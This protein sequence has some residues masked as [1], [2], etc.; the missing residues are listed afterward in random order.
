MPLNTSEAVLEM[1]RDAIRQELA[2]R[3]IPEHE[4]DRFNTIDRQGKRRV[5]DEDAA[6]QNEYNQRLA[7]A[8]QI[9]LR[10]AHG[11]ILEA[12]KPDG[13]KAV[14]N[15]QV[16]NQ[17]AE[18]RILRDHKQRLLAIK[19]DEVDQYQDLRKAVVAREHNKG[20]AQADFEQVR[21]PSVPIRPGPSRSR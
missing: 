4:W 11:T 6:W 20:R 16:L 12:P 9:I 14:P 1:Y 8:K 7:E 10:E 3:M 5:N 21:D 19:R 2:G 15:E 18:Q 13:I 17:K